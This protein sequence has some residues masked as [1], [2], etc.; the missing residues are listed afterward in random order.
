MKAPISLCM[1]VRNE[2]ALEACLK[3]VRDYVD[4]LVIIDTGSTDGTTQEV[5]RRYAD[6]FEVYTGCN[7]PKEDRIRNFSDARQ[8]GFDRARHDWVMWIDGDD[9]VRGAEHL[10]DLVAAARVKHEEVR[11]HPMQVMMPYVYA[12]DDQDR[13]TCL[14]ERERLI[15]RRQDFSWRG[16]VHEVLMPKS[17]GPLSYTVEQLLPGRTITIIHNRDR[18]PKKIESGRNLRI[19]REVYA[20]EGES[21]AR[22]L[23]YLGTELMNNNFIR[24]AVDML[25]RYTELS[26]WDEEKCAAMLT[27]VDCYTYQLIDYRKALD[28]AMRAVAVYDD[29]TEPYL[30]AARSCHYI[31][32]SATDEGV[33]R[34]YHE[35]CVRF[36]NR[37]L[38]IPPARTVLMS[39]P[40]NR[41]IDIHHYLNLSCSIIGD[42]EGALHS[43]ETGLAYRHDSN[44]AHNKVIYQDWLFRSAINQNLDK[45]VSIGKL[46]VDRR[47]KIDAIL[48]QPLSPEP[49]K[50]PAPESVAAAVNGVVASMQASLDGAVNTFA[51]QT[52]K[53]P[54]S[55]VAS[56]AIYVGNS[57]EA[58]NPETA[59]KSGIGGS[60]TAVIEMAKRLVRRG[61]KV[62]VWG[63]VLRPGVDLSGVFDGVEYR[64]H[65]GFPGTEADVLIA[66]RR[67]DVLDTIHRH[68]HRTSYTWIHDIYLYGLTP[69]RDTRI[70]HYLAL[71]EWHKQFLLSTY[72][73]VKPESIVVTQN[74]IDVSRFDKHVLRNPH[75]AIYASS[76]DRGLEA[77]L[78]M[79]PTIRREVPDAELHV[80]YGFEN[81]EFSA[82]SDPV[83]KATI[84]RIKALL[85]G[86]KSLGVTHHGRVDQATL[87]TAYMSSGVWYY[88][89]WFSET[90]CISAM[91]A[92]AAGLRI[93]T[94]PLAALNETVGSRGVLV[95]GDYGSS[96]YCAEFQ[97][98]TIAAMRKDGNEDRRV[99]QEYARQHFDWDV[100]ADAWCAMFEK[101][102]GISSVPDLVPY[103]SQSD[104]ANV[105]DLPPYKHIYERTDY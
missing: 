86:A 48:S 10:A 73:Y 95:P 79:W 46:D 16:R 2:P 90:S 68:K 83:Q 20:D 39:N 80:Y 24:E 78:N 105:P 81:W 63:D 9:E 17:G 67:A 82:Q 3:S 28:W 103:A 88:P 23:Y 31:A 64:D 89:T 6:T 13:P 30:A 15:G 4:D 47:S 84:L 44:L 96:V 50:A 94:S 60:E 98:A 100:V 97:R 70:G 59:K 27:I 102:L 49:E 42:V 8:R 53:P 11:R 72:N 1:I 85:D 12:R 38:A 101:H 75:R 35:R 87:A 57:V 54:G 21:D 69:D 33:K 19:L 66:S 76:P 92:Q 77:A 32:I 40:A 99:L 65:N 36:A 26:G 62:V 104:F 74:G 56:V 14:L 55:P 91:E 29:R 22:T 58:W 52:A 41:G 71:T 93:I 45:L 61:K 5:A 7:D 43:V 25:A 34:A 51:P 37:G 18:I